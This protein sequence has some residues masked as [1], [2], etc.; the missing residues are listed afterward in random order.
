[1]TKSVAAA[2]AIEIREVM[3]SSLPGGP[4][5]DVERAGMRPQ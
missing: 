4:Y 5:L 2:K 3:F 1:M